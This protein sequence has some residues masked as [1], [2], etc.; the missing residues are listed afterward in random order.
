MKEYYN[1]ITKENFELIRM[2][3]D[4]LNDIKKQIESNQE[5]VETLRFEMTKLQEPL[6]E[7]MAERERY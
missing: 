7:K 4:R 2:Y 6:A 5:M 1:D 3:N